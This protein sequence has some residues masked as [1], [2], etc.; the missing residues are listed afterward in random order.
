VFSDQLLLGRV[1]VALLDHVSESNW[2]ETIPGIDVSMDLR[3]YGPEKAVLD[4]TYKISRFELT[5]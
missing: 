4:G 3:I 1:F 2:I 5:K